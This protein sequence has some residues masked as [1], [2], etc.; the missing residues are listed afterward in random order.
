MRIWLLLFFLLVWVGPAGAQSKVTFTKKEIDKW[1]VF[2]RTFAP[3]AFVDEEKL[4]I[5]LD[6]PPF[7]TK[8]KGI[9]Q[10]IWLVRLD[11]SYKRESVKSYDLKLGGTVEQ[12]KLSPD[13]KYLVLVSRRGSQVDKL[14]LSDGQITNLMTHVKG[15][16]GF[17]LEPSLCFSA[18]DGFYVT[19]Y[20]YDAEDYGGKPT[21]A[22]LDLDQSGAAAFSPQ[23]DLR[24]LELGVPNA[25][26]L[27]FDSP[28]GVFFFHK[29][30]DQENSVTR[31]TPAGGYQLFDKGKRHL[32][33]WGSQEFVLYGMTRVDGSQDLVWGNA[34]T[35]EK[36]NLVS[37]TNR[38]LNPVLG[39]EGN[40]WVGMEDEGKGF[41][42]IVAASDRDPVV[43]KLATRTKG[44]ALRVGTLGETVIA[45]WP[46]G[47][48]TIY[49]LP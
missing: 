48:F 9:M 27:S 15:Q 44:A 6:N 20:P 1:G 4:F 39:H 26:V 14:R 12:A 2:T 45:H 32:G 8:R 41:F 42:S 28:D 33:V 21:I 35:G 46:N 40:A 22:K 24:K 34:K 13:R 16:A 23:V 11:A 43:K 37:G 47:E 3:L 31:W 36:K 30:G 7:T 10:R 19:G 29:T 18:G 38:I 17:R 25:T 49:K 5:G